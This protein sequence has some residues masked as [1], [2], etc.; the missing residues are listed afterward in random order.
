MKREGEGE[1]EGREEKG[2][3]REVKGWR[4]GRS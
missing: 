2:R 1:K 4:E 3:Q